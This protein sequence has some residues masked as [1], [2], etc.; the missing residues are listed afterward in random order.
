MYRGHDRKKVSDRKKTFSKH[1]CTIFL[2]PNI[3]KWE[4]YTKLPYIIPN[5]PKI[6][7]MIIKCNNIY[8]SKALQHLPKLGFLV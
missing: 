4:K 1:G 2:G 8:H 7:Q 6:F 3:P 5:V